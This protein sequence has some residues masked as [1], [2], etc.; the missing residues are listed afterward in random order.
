MAQ[1]LSVCG[2]NNCVSAHRCGCDEVWVW[3][4]TIRIHSQNSLLTLFTYTAL[5]MCTSW[6]TAQRLWYRIWPKAWH[7]YFEK[8]SWVIS[9][10]RVVESWKNHV[11]FLTNSFSRYVIQSLILSKLQFERWRIIHLSLH[12]FREY[13]LWFY[14][15]LCIN[16]YFSGNFSLVV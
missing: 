10:E 11:I 6:C 12:S 9:V 13:L 5:E 4:G 1:C 2:A 7:L 3:C 14:H 15:V 16:E 8:V